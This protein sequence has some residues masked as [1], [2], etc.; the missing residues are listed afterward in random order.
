MRNEEE[1]NL[2]LCFRPFLNTPEGMDDYLGFRVTPQE[3]VGFERHEPQIVV[4]VGVRCQVHYEKG[5]E[6]ESHARLLGSGGR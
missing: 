3:H 1:P 6:K 5:S 4:H 2:T